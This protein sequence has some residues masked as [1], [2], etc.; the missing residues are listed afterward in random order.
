MLSSS[1]ATDIGKRRKLNEDTV[2]AAPGLFVV[3]D[4]MG[5]HEA[6]EVASRLAT[7]VIASFIARSEADPEMTWP[8][9]FNTQMSYD[10]NRL[11]TAIKLANRA[12]FR[13]ASSVDAYTGMGKRWSL[14]SWPRIVRT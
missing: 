10:A 14:L 7:D 3:C 2:L 4:G 5:G 12:I 1:S 11:V 6:G 8:Y 13:K 9:G